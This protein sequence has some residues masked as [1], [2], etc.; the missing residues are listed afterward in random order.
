MRYDG[1]ASMCVLGDSGMMRQLVWNLVRNAV[2][3]S[4][5]GELVHDLAPRH[6]KTAAPSSSVIDRGIGID[7]AAKARLFDA[8]FTTRS[9]GTGM[10]L[11]VVKRIAD[12]H[13]FN[14]EVESDRESRGDLPCGARPGANETS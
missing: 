6:A 4:S 9:H 2:Q 3:A 7:P 1:P 13:G 14:I 12:E 10:G 5:A 11:A 8:F